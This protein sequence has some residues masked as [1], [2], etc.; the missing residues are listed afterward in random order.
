M[1]NN[2]EIPPEAIL[3]GVYLELQNGQNSIKYCHTVIFLFTTKIKTFVYLWSVSRQHSAGSADHQ[4]QSTP[5]HNSP[6][7]VARLSQKTCPTLPAVINFHTSPA[8]VNLLH[9]HFFWAPSPLHTHS[10]EEP[11]YL[12][13]CFSSASGAVW[14]EKRQSSDDWEASIAAVSMNCDQLTFYFH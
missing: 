7:D 4:T 11:W 13:S 14:N 6:E 5:A 8:Q 12:W 1:V 10:P 3:L 9:H 2:K